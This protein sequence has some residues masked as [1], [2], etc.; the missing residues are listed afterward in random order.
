MSRCPSPRLARVLLLAACLL[1]AARPGAAQPLNASPPAAT[2]KLVFVHHSTGENW[3]ADD[4][5]RLGIALR[6]NNYFVSDTNYG[7]GPPDE[8]AGS[9]TIG[10]HTDM[11]HWH[12]WF[13][14]PHR[15]AYLAALYAESGQHAS[16]ARRATDPGGP[17]RVV[18]F[19]SC[20]PNSHLG[21]SVDGPIPPIAQNPMRGEAA[22]SETYTVANAKGI[23]R[24]LLQYFAT[25]PDRLF[26][27]ATAPPLDAG[28]TDANAA[29]NARAFNDWLVDEWLVGYPQRNVFVFD[30]YNVLT[31]NGGSNR[32]NNPNVNDLG[33]AD[34]NH[35]RYGG[36]AIWHTRSVANH[37]SAYWSAGHDSHPS[38]AGNLKATGELVPLLNVAYH[39]WQGD[40]GCPGG[41]LAPDAVLTI[42]DQP[43]DGRFRATVSYQT[44][45]GGGFQGSGHAVSLAS[46][47]F[48]R[49]GAF[50]FF[51]ADNPEMLLKVLNGCAA[52]HHYWVYYSAG[53]N[54]GMTTTVTDTSTGAVWTRTNADLHPAE[55]AQDANAFPCDD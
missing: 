7:W 23:Y 55:P 10:D 26:V 46:A 18:L 36:G 16:Y 2:V 48:A 52:N 32:K 3:L 35:H 54:V 43:G 34:G 39:C 22:G 15:D 41:T 40:G 5:G 49:G 33:W 37:T 47:G 17:N 9:E 51:G 24:Q 13:S 12:S 20:F 1:P 11:G 4:N 14:G 53:T 27:V 6:D 29:A 21:G 25:R 44:S 8:D 50:W 45:Q 28:E 42:D 19:K 38:V 30:F 31:S